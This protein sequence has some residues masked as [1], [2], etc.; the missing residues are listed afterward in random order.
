[1]L[2]PSILRRVIGHQG[3]DLEICPALLLEHTRHKVQ[4]A[5]YPGVIPYE[6]SRRLLGKELPPEDRTVRG[7]VVRGLSDNDVRLLDTFEGDEYVRATVNVH[8]LGPFSPLESAAKDSAIV[9]TTP[10]PLSPEFIA[11]L[12][13]THPPIPANT[14]LWI[15][16]IS[17]LKPDIWDYAEFVRDNA[18][19]WVGSAPAA[20]ENEYYLE[21]DRR[22]EMDGH[23]VRHEIVNV[24][25]EERRVVVEVND[26]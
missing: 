12:P 21:V 24:G 22:R 11:T 4:H 10:P 1:M 8:P 18:W 14:Y 16:P 26:G 15:Q 23:I 20:R 3:A 19:K 13:S 17:E 2:H 25:E 5:D 6:K 7:T 9:P